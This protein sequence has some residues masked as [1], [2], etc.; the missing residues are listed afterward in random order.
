MILSLSFLNDENDN[1]VD[2]DDN[3]WLAEGM[4]GNATDTEY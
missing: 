4:N 1:G 3:G 2:A